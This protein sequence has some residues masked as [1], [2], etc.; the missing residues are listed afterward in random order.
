[1]FFFKKPNI[2]TLKA[3]NNVK[4]LIKALN[5]KSESMEQKDIQIRT[6][7]LVALGEIGDTQ[8][9]IPIIN[10]INSISIRSMIQDKYNRE[11]REVAIIALGQIGNSQAVEYL[12]NI[13]GKTC[14]SIHTFH[15]PSWKHIHIIRKQCRCI[16]EILG[17]IGDKHATHAIAKLLIHDDRD[18]RKISVETLDKC[19]WQPQQDEDAVYYWIAKNELDKCLEIGSDAVEPAILLLSHKDEELQFRAA[20]LLSQI[21]S[22]RAIESLGDFLKNTSPGNRRVISSYLRAGNGNKLAIP[23]LIDMLRDNDSDTCQNSA[24]A[25]D[26]CG[27]QPQQDEDAVYYWIAKNEFDKCVELGS[28]AVNPILHRYIKVSSSFTSM[29]ENSIIKDAIEVAIIKIGSP[30]V[31]PILHMLRSE[32]IR[33]PSTLVVDMMLV[34]MMRKLGDERAVAPL[35]KI[36]KDYPPKQ[37][38]RDSVIMAAIRALGEIGDEQAVAP[39]I[40][41][42]KDY[43]PKQEE[44]CGIIGAAADAL[45]KI[46]DE[47]GVLPLIEAYKRRPHLRQTEL[48]RYAQLYGVTWEKFLNALVQIGEPAVNSLV[49]LLQVSTK[50]DSIVLALGE[51]GDTRA[52][53]P[54]IEKMKSAS[55]FSKDNGSI[56]EVLGKFGDTRAVEPLIR[57]INYGNYHRTIKVIKALGEIGDERAVEPLIH[58][59][60]RSGSADIMIQA[61]ESLGKIGD[62]RAIEPLTETLSKY[63][64]TLS[65]HRIKYAVSRAL[66]KLSE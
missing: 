18:I 54:L 19:G 36:V 51:I 12:I 29:S 23:I 16:A 57:E 2:Q 34:D 10:I 33:N 65:H 5:Y 55:I 56:P 44:Y 27:W 52:I 47:R 58:A 31:E 35:I 45:G 60:L 3:K 39:L 14:E 25:L 6:D 22:D 1:M 11:L 28:L 21:G 64:G 13:L 17:E 42:V 66:G 9:T 48:E 37:S 63:D 24:E 4:G 30:A 7:A 46:G 49:S 40:K 61:A 53:E 59:L 15:D 41:I 43:P 38:D 20:V 50:Y 62:I 26:K 32:S 8:A